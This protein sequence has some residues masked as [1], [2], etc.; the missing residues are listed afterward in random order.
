MKFINRIMTMITILFVMD[1]CYIA[2]SKSSIT[3]TF[4]GDLLLD[5]GVKE[6]INRLGV[7]ALFDSTIDSLFSA[8]D[9]VIANLECPA[10]AIWQPINKKY[11]FQADPALLTTL[12][13][14]GITHL[15]MANNHSM[16]QGRRGLVDT[17]KNIISAEITPTGYGDSYLEACYPQLISNYPRKVF[18]LSSV[19]V[20]S[21]NWTFLPNEPSVCE[22]TVDELSQ[23]IMDLR[24][25]FSQCVIVIQVHWGAEHTLT[26]MTS[27]KQ[28][29]HKLI[30]AGADVIIGHH[31]HTIQT[32]ENYKGKPIYYSIGNFIFDQSKPI[33]SKGLAVSIDIT[34]YGI[35]IKDREFNI[36]KCKPCLVN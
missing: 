13:K 14:H 30:D 17:H 34:K 2:E 24:R 21:E 35:S 36:V 22:A 16:D 32:I 12:K 3:L 7:D 33:N 15:N 11:I 28:Q 25:M 20:P 10:T 27:Q 4:V 19:L 26:P 9:I 5:R 8:S 29:A 1:G 23:S 18:V 31:T 6:R